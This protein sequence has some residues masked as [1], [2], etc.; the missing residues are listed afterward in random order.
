M[1]TR[2]VTSQGG[3]EDEAK[4]IFQDALIVF[5]QKATNSDF[6]LS[7]KLSTYL[8]SVCQN[9]WRKEFDRK[10]RLVHEAKDS[11][12]FIE[13]DKRERSFIIRSCIKALPVTCR[14]V[15]TY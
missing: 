7:S 12:V 11:E 15:L 2:V 10:S 5:W 9:L 3:N 14:K 6:I 4:D 13:E 1:M 8:Y